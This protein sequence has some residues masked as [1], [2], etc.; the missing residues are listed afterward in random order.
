MKFFTWICALFAGISGL[1]A[2]F[3]SPGVGVNW[4]LDS[5]AVYDPEAVVVTDTGYYILK[6]IIM[7]V[8]DT[9]K[10]NKNMTVK[11]DGGLEVRAKG[12]F[13]SK[14]DSIVI[15][16][17]A[18]TTPY[19]GLYFEETA[20]V[21]FENTTVTYGGG[22]RV[23]TADFQMYNCDVSNNPIS[24][25]STGSA[26]AFSR[27][28]PVI[29]NS[30]FKFNYNPALSSG[31][32][33]PVAAIIDGNYFEA[34]NLRGN[35]RPQINMGPS[36]EDT[37]FITNNVVIGD[38]SLTVVGGVSASSLLGVE[39]H[40]VISDNI[41]RDNRYGITTLGPNTTG[42]I[43]NNVIEDNNTETNPNNGGSGI[44]LYNTGLIYVTNNQIRRNLW[45]VTSIGT[46]ITN[47]GS[48]DAEDYNPGGNVF[49][50]NGNGGVVYALFNNT[51]NVLKALHNCWIEGMESTK[52]EA[53]AVIF[54]VADIET[55]GE[56]LYDPFDCGIISNNQELV[57]AEGLEVYP[58]P[59]SEV[60][61][62]NSPAA[63]QLNVYDA[64][65]KLVRRAIAINAGAQTLSLDVKS[66]MYIL[67]L[68]ADNQV[69]M[70]KLMVK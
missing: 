16:A 40:I 17:I 28:K 35:N 63:G 32:N 38:R 58:N 11:I 42:V 13:E 5:I 59:A 21:Y 19:K 61:Q 22:I 39:N 6:G 50:E 44:S 37:I 1:T 15:T 2:Q 7:E 26:I 31:A 24:G 36:G 52:E 34:N 64:S 68:N 65:G 56:V 47:M 20:S 60:F 25:S 27:G 9:L 45:G 18:D 14:A 51:A 41:V 49:S 12:M 62:L 55:L 29:K 46:A 66:G 69:I 8:G 54:D 67:Q 70:Q 30:T 48:D 23:I 43:A 10:L 4:T 3:T 57:Q 33:T 53:G